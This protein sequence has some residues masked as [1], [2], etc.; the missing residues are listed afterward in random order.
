MDNGKW[1]IDN[2]ILHNF[3]FSVIRFPLTVIRFPFHIVG[4]LNL[5]PDS[6]FDG[7]KFVGINAAVRRAGEMLDEGADI[8]E[9][10]GESTGPG[11]KDVS[12]DEELSRVIPVLSKL[13]EAYPSAKFSIDT[14]KASVAKEALVSGVC[15]V[16]DVTAGRGDS[17]LF[18]LLAKSDVRIVL[19]YAKDMTPRTTK[20]PQDYDD[21]VATVGAFLS[22]RIAEAEK[23]GI[24]RD[25]IIIDPGMG[26]FL[27]SK[28]EYSFEVI[29]RLREFTEIAP[30][31]ISPSRKSFLAGPENL[32]ASERLPGTIVASAM[33]ARNGA[34]YIRTHDVG[35]VKRGCEIALRC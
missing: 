29:R 31:F 18:S 30:V 12:V 21:V 8:I 9:V 28:P 33:A 15:M 19:M 23:A 5:T 24:A 35:P 27:S 1:I 34:S 20:E 3:P 11:S 4:V 17:A 10:G 13:R 2:N 25:R 14:Y 32:P 22:D 26:H 16:N 6:Y 7:G